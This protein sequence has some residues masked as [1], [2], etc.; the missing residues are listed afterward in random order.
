MTQEP[1]ELTERPGQ[2]EIGGPATVVITRVISPEHRDDYERWLVRMIAPAARFPNNLG[3]VVLTP[4]PGDGDVFRL[5]HRFA[6]EEMED[7][8]R[9]VRCRVRHYVDHHPASAGMA[10]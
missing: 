2:T 8:R 1:I 7:G 4:K 9:H 5:V 6:A 10:S 3:A